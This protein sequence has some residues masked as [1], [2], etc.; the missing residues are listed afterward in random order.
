[1]ELRRIRGD[2]SLS[3]SDWKLAASEALPFEGPAERLQLARMASRERARAAAQDAMTDEEQQ[4]QFERNRELLRGTPEDQAGVITEADAEEVIEQDRRMRLIGALDAKFEGLEDPA[5]IA[6]AMLFETESGRELGSID[7][8]E[9]SGMLDQILA[10]GNPTEAMGMLRK[11]VETLIPFLTT[12]ATAWEM[13]EDEE[14]PEPDVPESA[15]D[16]DVVDVK[17]VITEL[18]AAGGWEKPEDEDNG[19][20]RGDTAKP[21]QE[22][23]QRCAAVVGDAVGG[24]D[25]KRHDLLGIIYGE[26]S[27][28][29]LNAWE[30]GALLGRWQEGTSFTA[31]EQGKREAHALLDAHSLFS[32]FT[33]NLET[34][35]P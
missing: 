14:S 32:Q 3:L 1:M 27:T 35:S 29:A 6:D 21:A 11:Q 9:L 15:A 24:E 23:M 30:V 13:L 20:T 26:T 2:I 25:A 5:A 33:D 18:R 16:A 12:D 10:L 28:K 7:K 4:A 19:W 34:H 17:T 22:V 8:K 31:N